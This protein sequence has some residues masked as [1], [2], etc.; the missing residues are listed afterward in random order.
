[1]RKIT[2]K[3]SGV[4]I[5]KADRIVGSIKTL[6]TGAKRSGLLGKIGGFSGL[7]S[8]RFKGMRDPV[9]AASTDGVGTKLMLADATSKHN[10]IGIDLVAMC[11]NDIIACGA[12]PLFFLDYF[13]TGSLN[14]A[15]MLEVMKGIL[16]G[17]KESGCSL[18]GGETAEL[19]GLYKNEDYDLAGFSIGVVDKKA[20]IDGSRI[21]PGDVVLGIKS[22]GPH[23]NGYSLIRKLFSKN[24]IRGKFK[25][26]LLMPTAIYVKPVLAILK[27]LKVNGIAHITGGGFYDNILRILPKE[28]AVVLNPSSWTVPKIFKEIQKRSNLGKVDMYKTFN[29]GIGMAL[30]LKRKDAGTAG[31]ILARYKMKSFIIG[32]VV[33]GKRKVVI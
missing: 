16:K 5:D 20:I 11:V 23:S 18:L 31:S 2:Y 27:K 29:M 26:E 30:I 32:E 28:C 9:L 15:K 7:F 25:K 33:K 8:A 19:P 24:E 10:T 3:D 17:C 13:A 12:E 21:K 4:D 14:T 22:S 1:M 6:G